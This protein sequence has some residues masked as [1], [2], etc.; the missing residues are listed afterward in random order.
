MIDP[1]YRSCFYDQEMSF[2]S[3][4]LQRLVK[5]H[6]MMMVLSAERVEE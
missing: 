3:S 6:T 1:D 2:Y 4:D 5:Y